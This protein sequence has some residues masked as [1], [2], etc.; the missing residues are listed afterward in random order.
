MIVYRN[1]DARF[2][3]LWESVDQ[4]EA[5]W[6]GEGEGPTHYF[7]D[8]P[9]GAWAEFVRHEEIV[10]LADLA[11]VR[12]GICAV[13][14]NPDECQ[15]PA[16]PMTVLTG[17]ETTYDECRRE[18]NRMRAAGMRGVMAPSAALRPGAAAGLRVD[19][20][21]QDGPPRDGFVY[22]LFGL[23][24]DLI[25]WRIATEARPPVHVLDQ[26]AYL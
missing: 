16:L 15:E 7:A 13:D 24:P 20:G 4:P 5:R 21:T 22:V 6:H 17:D 10:E 9:N 12:R 26:V 18:A 2:P 11:G 14:I 23:R 3:F 19:R 25:G 1:Y 8:T